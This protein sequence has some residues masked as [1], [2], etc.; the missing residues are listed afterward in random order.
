[1]RAIL[2]C[3]FAGCLLTG[4]AGSPGGRHKVTVTLREYSAP[5]GGGLPR[6]ENLQASMPTLI[7]GEVLFEHQSSVHAAQEKT[8]AVK[9][10]HQEYRFNYSVGSERKGSSPVEIH[11]EVV[12]KADEVEGR[13]IYAKRNV[14]GKQNCRWGE[15]TPMA[16]YGKNHL[17]LVTVGAPKAR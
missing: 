3:V 13:P 16:R 17:L 10:G 5:D 4:C 15:S 2:L 7:P 12:E 1:M 6:S 9:G 14:S 8:F 11:L